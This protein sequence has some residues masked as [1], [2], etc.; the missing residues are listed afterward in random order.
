[1]LK[2]LL[3]AALLVLPFATTVDLANAQGGPIPTCFPCP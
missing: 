2:K 3:L 1:M